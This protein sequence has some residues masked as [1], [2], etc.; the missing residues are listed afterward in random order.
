[1]PRLNWI[2]NYKVRSGPLR[3]LSL[4][5]GILAIVLAILIVAIIR[6][7]FNFSTSTQVLLLRSIVTAT[8]TLL[9]FTLASNASIQWLPK[10]TVRFLAIAVA[11]PVAL[12]GVYALTLPTNIT[13]DCCS[14]AWGP[15]SW[16][17]G[18]AARGWA[19]MSMV[20]III[21]LIATLIYIYLERDREAKE[22]ALRFAL[23]KQTLEKEALSVRL[24][25]LQAQVEPHFL[26]NTLANVQQL[27]E[28]QSPRA[29]PMLKNLIQYLKLTIAQTRGE[30]TCAEKEFELARNYLAIMQ[31]R[32]PDRLEYSVQLPA[33]LNAAQLPPLALLTLVEN[34]VKHGID[35]A[36]QGGAVQVSA[37]A[38]AEQLNIEVADTGSGLGSKP[39]H[40]NGTGLANLR[41][42]LQAQYGAQ[43]SLQLLENT[44]RGVVARLSL[45]LVLA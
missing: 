31:T 9:A 5:Q 27:V 35:A 16:M 12:M 20:A 15:L 44:P 25:A 22:Q 29:G 1:M 45:P 33:A 17:G 14:L 24:K 3:G 38:Q 37:V 8:F 30:T 34:A 28:M 41:E 39:G 2:P 21:S 36:E 18:D 10:H 6:I 4:Y 32:M 7:A 19:K 43:A 23:D 11:S 40:G 13:D 26:F 42:R